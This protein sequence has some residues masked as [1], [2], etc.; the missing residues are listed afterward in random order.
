MTPESAIN[1]VEGKDKS[2]TKLTQK[3]IARIGEST[4]PPH[5]L[6]LT[7]QDVILIKTLLKKGDYTDIVDIAREIN[8]TKRDS[9]I[10]YIIA[11]IPTVNSQFLSPLGIT[12]TSIEKDDNGL[13]RI[14]K[15]KDV[16]NP[17]SSLLFGYLKNK[18][19]LLDRE[20]SHITTTVKKTQKGSIIEGTTL[21]GGKLK[22]IL[23]KDE[24][25]TEL[26]A[27][28]LPDNQGNG[29]VIVCE[30]GKIPQEQKVKPI[31]YNISSDQQVKLINILL[32]EGS[33]SQ[34]NLLSRFATLEEL[35]SYRNLQLLVHCVNK[36]MRPWGVKAFFEEEPQNLSLKI[37][38]EEK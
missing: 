21:T 36:R 11:R 22:P 34:A 2:F 10:Q 6:R 3:D 35:L 33:I 26:P 7:K 20:K 37:I 23:I 18:D 17:E 14:I 29:I 5:D 24:L 38:T 31:T 13:L 30:Q 27:N 16:K 19:E 15:N 32:S 8:P 28:A 4:I 12:I 25:I 1:H 9:E